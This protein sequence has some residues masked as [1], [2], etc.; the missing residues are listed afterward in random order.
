MTS[1]VKWIE[2]PKACGNSAATDL[3]FDGL[4]TQRIFNALFVE[5]LASN[6]QLVSCIGYSLCAAIGKRNYYVA[7]SQHPGI[8]TL[9]ISDGKFAAAVVPLH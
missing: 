5:A 2:S 6:T 4:S 9:S 7:R 3:I 1:R 8:E